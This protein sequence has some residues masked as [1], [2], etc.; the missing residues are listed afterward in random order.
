M[1]QYVDIIL[2]F[3]GS[4]T[5]CLLFSSSWATLWQDMKTKTYVESINIPLQYSSYQFDRIKHSN[6]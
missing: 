1:K 2:L 4:Q 6:F 5:Q 3:V